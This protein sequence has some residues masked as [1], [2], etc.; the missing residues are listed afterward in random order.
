MKTIEDGNIKIMYDSDKAAIFEERTIKGWWS[1]KSSAAGKSRFWDKDERM[2][3]WDG[4]T[5]KK[6]ECGEV[7]SKRWTCCKKCRDK[8]KRERFNKLPVIEWDGITPI[9][10]YDDDRFFFY[11]SDLIEYCQEHNCKP[12]DLMLVICE[13]IY[14]SQIDTDYWCDELGEDEEMPSDILEALDSLNEIISTA[15]PLSWQQGEK[16]IKVKEDQV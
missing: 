6:C 16:R 7:H 15:D 4:C 13:P 10:S 2:A 12:D 5:H 9:C 11:E 14:P 3:R 8:K 1:V